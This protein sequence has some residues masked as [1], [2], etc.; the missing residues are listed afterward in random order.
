MSRP[1]PSADAAFYLPLAPAD[2]GSE[3]FA[4]TEHTVGPWSLAM[5]HMAPPSALLVRALE[6]C[7]PREGTRLVR[8]TLEVLGVVPRAD[9]TVRTSVV[10]PGR[11]IELLAAELLATAPDGTERAVVRAA[12]WRMAAHDTSGQVTA[13]DPVL[14]PVE[15]GVDVEPPE[16]WL[17]GY[18]D[19]LE[20]RWLEGFLDAQGRGEVW[21]RP[22]VQ[23]V[24]GEEPTELQA[25]FAVIDS[26]NGVGAPLDVREF[27]FLNTDLTVHLHRA[28]VGPW[29]GIAAETSIG[30]DGVGT[31]SAVLH[32][33]HGAFGRSAQILL[34]R[35]RG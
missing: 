6:R 11:Q 7:S 2:D 17:P 35:P 20:W 24:A 4:S 14:A 9:L 31:C 13:P 12:G 16:H 5:Q 23:V 10:R 33:S 19:A 27:T 21:A 34:V 8:V 28:P 29:T 25:A 18:L 30:P 32:D 15:D 3:R 22:R 1:V 26:A